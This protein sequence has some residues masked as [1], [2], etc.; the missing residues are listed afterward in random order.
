MVNWVYVVLKAS[1]SSDLEDFRRT[2]SPH[3]QYYLGGGRSG[4]WE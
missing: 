1:C 2:I 4:E 3:R